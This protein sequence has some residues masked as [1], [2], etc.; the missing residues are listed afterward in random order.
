MDQLLSWLS[1]Y[2]FFFSAAAGASILLLVVSVAATPWF[3]ASLPNDYLQHK[4]LGSR[5]RGLFGI[6]IMTFRNIVG[7]ILVALGL[8]LMVTP[9]PGLVVLLIGISLAEFSGKQHLL[10]SIAIKPNVFKTL[11]WMRTRR[12]KPPFDYPNTRL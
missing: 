7:L 8:I 2:T 5:P 1:E 6:L 4:V 9:G 10:I 12:G 3:V 11:N